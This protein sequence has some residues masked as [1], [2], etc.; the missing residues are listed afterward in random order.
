MRC[1]MGAKGHFSQVASAALVWHT[2]TTHGNVWEPREHKG[3]ED[4]CSLRMF[5]NLAMI[6]IYVVLQI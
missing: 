3:E 1:R 4:I 2:C 5:K 6:K